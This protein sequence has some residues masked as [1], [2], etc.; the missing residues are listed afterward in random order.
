MNGFAF[1]TARR[2][3]DAFSSLM[4]RFAALH[5]FLDTQAGP[6]D[7]PIRDD[8]DEVQRVVDELQ[9]VV[10]PLESTSASLWRTGVFPRLAHLLVEDEYT[11]LV[12][13]RGAE[14]R[15]VD[16]VTVLASLDY[17]SPAFFAA[18]DESAETFLLELWHGSWEVYPAE[19]ALV[20]AVASKGFAVTEVSSGRW[21]QRGT[22]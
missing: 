14:D 21:P 13:F 18:V 22:M 15:V 4:P 1:R 19:K 16:A 17:L 8:A 6:F 11:Y 9:I 3:G 7:Y 12:G 10:A 20:D 2:F 5:W